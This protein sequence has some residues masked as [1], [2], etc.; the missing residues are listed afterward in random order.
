MTA[1]Q[2]ALELPQTR[3]EGP[4]QRYAI[5]VQGCS[6]RCPGCCNPQ[7]LPARDDPALATPVNAIVQRIAN[8]TDIEGITVLGGEPFEQAAALVPLLQGVQARGLSTMVFTGYTLDELERRPDATAALGATDLLVD[9]RYDRTRPD[10]TRRWIGSSNQ[11]MH[12]LSD[13]YAPTDP[14]FREPE[15]V[16]L[17]L[18]GQHLTVN[19]TPWGTWRPRRHGK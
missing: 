12:W 3:A 6:L 4:G 1:L 16:E 18:R 10:G 13:R 7:F 17:R 14:R 2:V 8:T 5:W 9:G 19:G 11:R 15:T